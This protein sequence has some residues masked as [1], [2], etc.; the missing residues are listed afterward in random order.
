MKFT[1]IDI[2]ELDIANRSEV[3]VTFMYDKGYLTVALK[4]MLFERFYKEVKEDLMAVHSDKFIKEETANLI[5]N[6]TINDFDIVEY[7]E[8][9]TGF[10]AELDTIFQQY[11]IIRVLAIFFQKNFI[12]FK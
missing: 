12:T 11:L 5:L 4:A 8:E 3:Y 7:W 1:Q 2:E 10:F 9:E 6:S